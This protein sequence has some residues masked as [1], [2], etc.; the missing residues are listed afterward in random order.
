[1]FPAD[2]QERG[3]LGQHFLAG[4]LTQAGAFALVNV[5]ALYLQQR[6]PHDAMVASKTGFLHA[7]G[8]LA[9]MLASPLWGALNDRGTA[10]RTFVLA[11]GGCAIALALLPLAG[12]LWQIGALRVVQGA[13]FAALAQSMLSRCCARLPA[14]LHGSATGIARSAMTAGQLVGPLA[15]M[16]WL[17]HSDPAGT[18]WLIAAMFA[19]AAA[20]VAP[21]RSSLF[22]T[23]SDAR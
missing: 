13:L 21:D 19:L 7:L 18:L 8:W 23:V 16:A 6:F 12:A 22:A 20:L 1:M 4:C 11:A 2:D 9:A 5:F 10:V 17:P 3:D 15:V 14:G